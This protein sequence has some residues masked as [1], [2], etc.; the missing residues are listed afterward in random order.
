LGTPVYPRRFFDEVLAGLGD[1]I[2]VMVVYLEGTP[3]STALLV[4]W[5]DSIK[6]PW[7]A[8]LHSVNPMAINMRLYWELLQHA[9]DLRCQKFDFGRCTRDAG[10]YRFKAQWGALPIQLY[11][12]THA[13]EDVDSVTTVLNN[14]SKLDGAV[15]IWSKLPL[16]VANLLGPTISHR[17]PW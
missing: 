14:R 3:V 10:T 8:T 5:R 11:W 12:R 13:L 2:S 6:V 15:R 16:T 4:R 9:I 1:K 17:L 7:A